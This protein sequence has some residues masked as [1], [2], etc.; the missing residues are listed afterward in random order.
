MI[1]AKSTGTVA[2]LGEHS[3]CMR[4]VEG[5]IPSGSTM[6][7]SSNGKML[8]SQGSDPGSIPGDSTKESIMEQIKE[9]NVKKNTGF[10]HGTRM[11]YKAGCLCDECQWVEADR[12][13]ALADRYGSLQK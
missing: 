13:R 6:G 7:S 4:E 1:G 2:Q 3:F 11:S 5:S 10:K 12:K 8:L 9:K